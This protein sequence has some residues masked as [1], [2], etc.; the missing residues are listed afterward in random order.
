M[1]LFLKILGGILY[2]FLIVLTVSVYLGILVGSIYGIVW[3]WNTFESDTE[4]KIG[5]TA[6]FV[7][8]FFTVLTLVYFMLDDW[9]Q[10]SRRRY[11]FAPTPSRPITPTP[12]R[13]TKKP[14]PI[15]GHNKPNRAMTASVDEQTERIRRS[16][17]QAKRDA[18]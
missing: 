17:L 9:N 5:V 16:L 7:I 11:T 3:T 8:L 12:P 10:P 4:T 14:E 2:G 13:E 18:N 1:K 6:L 15:L